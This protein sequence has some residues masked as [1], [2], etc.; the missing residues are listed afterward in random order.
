[1][2]SM[3][4]AVVV[5]AAGFLEDAGEL[6]AAGTHVFNV[7]RR[8]GVA[9]FEGP[10]FLGGNRWCDDGFCCGPLL[11]HGLTITGQGD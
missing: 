5:E 1:M 3:P 10:L 4:V 8:R 9:V 11:G 2:R 7:R 6:Q